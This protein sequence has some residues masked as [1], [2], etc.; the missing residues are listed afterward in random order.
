[1]V[2]IGAVRDAER[3]YVIHQKADDAGFRGAMMMR[4]LRWSGKQESDHEDISMPPQARP[5]R[6]LMRADFSA[7]TLRRDDDD[8]PNFA[9]MPAGADSRCDKICHDA[10]HISLQSTIHSL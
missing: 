1:M 10:R 8:A 4:K 9:A 3:P 5:T 7:S 2:D 6:C